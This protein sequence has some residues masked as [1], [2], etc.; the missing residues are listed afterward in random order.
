MMA[1]RAC[2]EEA[3]LLIALA[4]PVLLAQISMVSMGFVD[5]VM[6][7]RVG[8]EDMA[9]VALAGSL[10]IPLVLFFQGILLAVTPITAQLRGAGEGEKSGHVI[11]QGLG[12]ALVMAVLLIAIIFG[13]SYCLEDLGV[14]ARLADLTAR[15]LRAVIWGGVPF[16]LFVDRKSVV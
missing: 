13:L 2:L 14:E 12:M 5:M 15:Y 6:T 7:G 16:L 3:R 11:R 4:A 9:A 8:P 1:F 10:W